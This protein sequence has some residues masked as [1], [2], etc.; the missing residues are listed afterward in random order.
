MKRL[1]NTTKT[2]HVCSKSHKEKYFHFKGWYLYQ[3]THTSLSL[4]TLFSCTH[5]EPIWISFCLQNHL[6]SDKEFDDILEAFFWNVDACIGW[7]H[8]HGKR[9]L[10]GTE[11]FWIGGGHFNTGKP[12]A[13]FHQSIWHY[14]L[15]VTWCIVLLE[16]VTKW[17]VHCSYKLEDV[18]I[19]DALGKTARKR[20]KKE[21]KRK[22]KEKKRR[23]NKEKKKLQTYTKE[24]MRK[25]QL[26]CVWVLTRAGG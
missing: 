11:I 16:V 1:K 25:I 24:K 3:H 2:F 23:N 15:Y 17:W 7:L 6:S 5:L 9:G 13:M 26:H 14:F 19:C 22:M 8:H 20:K 12:F 10:Y 4:V 18:V 21:K